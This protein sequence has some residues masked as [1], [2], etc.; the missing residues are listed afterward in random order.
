MNG[1]P[2][3]PQYTLVV[4]ST[5]LPRTMFFTT[6]YIHNDQEDARIIHFTVIVEF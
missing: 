5:V 1:K 3:S 2:T 4:Y 6:E